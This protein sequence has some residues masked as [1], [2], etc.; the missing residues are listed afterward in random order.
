MAAQTCTRPEVAR[1]GEPDEN[2]VGQGQSFLPD[3]AAAT[4]GDGGELREIAGC[5]EVF[6]AGAPSRFGLAFGA[7]GL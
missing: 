7:F 6:R 4:A 1:R 3:S 5:L 2:Y